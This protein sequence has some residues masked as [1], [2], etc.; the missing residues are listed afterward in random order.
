MKV[1]LKKIVIY[2]L[3]LILLTNIDIPILERLNNLPPQIRDTPQ[4]KMLGNNH[5]T[6]AHIVKVK[7][8]LH[9]EDILGFCKIFKKVT[10]NSGFHV[11]LK[12][13]DLQNFIL[14][15]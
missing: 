7:G 6:D 13:N 5:H 11:M 3:N 8:Y 12:T 10:K 9:L 4:Q 14:H 15:V 2:Y 1:I